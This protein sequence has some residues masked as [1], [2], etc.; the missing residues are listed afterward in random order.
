[1][2]KWVTVYLNDSAIKKLESVRKRMERE[3]GREVS[4]GEVI[5]D[6]LL[7]RLESKDGEG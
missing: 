1:M 3:L 4:F 6:L 7:E 5:K 2:G